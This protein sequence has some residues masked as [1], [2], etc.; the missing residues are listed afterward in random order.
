MDILILSLVAG[1]VVVGGIW[2]VT[3]E[4]KPADKQTETHPTA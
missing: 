1:L 4:T 2:I 3:R